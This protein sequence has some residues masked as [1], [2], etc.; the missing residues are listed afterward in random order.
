MGIDFNGD[1]LDKTSIG[2]EGQSVKSIV[3][4]GLLIY[5]DAQD[6]DSYSSGTTWTDLS[7]NGNHFTTV[8]GTY[9]SS[10][11]S[12]WNFS[13]QSQLAYCANVVASDYFTAECV[14]R[15]TGEEAGDDILFNKEN[16]WEVRTNGSSIQW[17]VYTSNVSWY[18]SNVIPSISLNTYYH[19]ALTYDGVN[20]KTYLNGVLKDTTSYTGTLANQTS[21]WP[22]LNAR[23]N[24]QTT[25][26]GSHNGNHD[27]YIFRLYNR[28]L[29]AT[30]V[31]QNYN[32]S[33]SRFGFGSYYNCG[34][35]CQYYTYNP[36]CT[37]C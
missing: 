11:P 16:T 34:Y 36:G 33:K 10:A 13:G 22:K 7:G 14:F 1:N 29:S 18:W 19:M 23:G 4:N 25:G 27:F 26:D 2:L 20:L 12:K 21:A 8:G 32:A 37:A 3:R 28:G 6:K 5:L 30:E 35:G 9:T 31:L 17:A 24:A 15:K